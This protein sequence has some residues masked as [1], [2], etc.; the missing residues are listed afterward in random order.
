MKTIITAALL[1]A[2]HLCAYAQT[3]SLPRYGQE[4][5]LGYFRETYK[6]RDLQASPMMYVANLNGMKIF[7]GRIT[8]KNQWLVN[9]KAGKADF[10][11]PGLGVRQ[12]YFSEDG[13]PLILVPTL[14]KGELS[15]AYRRKLVQQA[16]RSSWAGVQIQE[17]IQYAD[18]L[19]L[20]T[21]VMN[22]LA[23]NLTY[24]MQIQLHERHL[25]LADVYLPVVSAVSRLPYSNVVST[26]GSSNAKA[27]LKNSALAGP[28][29][30]L[31][32]QVNIA[33]RLTVSKRIGLQASYRY[34]LLRYPEP[35][36]IRSA[37]HTADLSLIYQWHF[38]SK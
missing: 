30:Y 34:S 23:L 5:H 6:M 24:Q 12:F 3:T 35:K 20:N 25:V 32:P 37:S 33:Y 29:R 9:I 1:L 17:N 22:S 7:Y 38:Q 4:L 18:G 31:N 2:L 19:A 8:Q 13:Q 16:N 21:W 28:F 27:F 36:M 10:V 11:A 26:P 14:Y 15:F